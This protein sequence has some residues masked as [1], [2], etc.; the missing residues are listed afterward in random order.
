MPVAVIAPLI[1]AVV[2]ALV[3]FAAGTAVGLVIGSREF[4]ELPDREP[5]ASARQRPRHG[6]IRL[7]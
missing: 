5:L 3:L 4:D 1:F 2:L 7:G 6:E